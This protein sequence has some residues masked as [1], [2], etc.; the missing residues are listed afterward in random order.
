MIRMKN[1]NWSTILHSLTHRSNKLFAPATKIYMCIY[2]HL[3]KSSIILLRSVPV[4]EVDPTMCVGSFHSV[5]K[6]QAPLQASGGIIWLRQDFV[7]KR[8]ESWNVEIWRQQKRPL[9]VRSVLRTQSRHRDSGC[10]QDRQF[11]NY[12][13]HQEPMLK[14]QRVVKAWYM[15][16]STADSGFLTSVSHVER[17]IFF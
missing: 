8:Y 7:E 4:K 11:S 1:C 10:D 5:S 12:C 2:V 6:P 17:P 16:W 14:T 13:M 3:D 15:A 9:E